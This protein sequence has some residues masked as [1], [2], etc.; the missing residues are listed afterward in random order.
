MRT[1][2]VK[3]ADGRKGDKTLTAENKAGA[4][5]KGIELYKYGFAIYTNRRIIHLFTKKEIREA[6]YQFKIKGK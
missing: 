1:Y 2:T 4:I 6:P 3:F 5:Q